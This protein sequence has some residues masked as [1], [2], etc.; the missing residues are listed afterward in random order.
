MLK[1]QIDQ[2]D[3]SF[4]ESILYILKKNGENLT[5]NS[6]GYFFDLQKISEI[7]LKELSNMI[8]NIQNNTIKPRNSFLTLHKTEEDKCLTLPIDN[9]SEYITVSQKFLS[10]YNNDIQKAKEK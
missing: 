8:V 2:L 6:T 1:T 7:S 10:E 9:K 3:P 4:H 5:E